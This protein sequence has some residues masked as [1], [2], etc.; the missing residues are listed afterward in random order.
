MRSGAGVLPFAD[1]CTHVSNAR[2]VRTAAAVVDTEQ[3]P[4]AGRSALAD[5]VRVLQAVRGG[6]VGAE[7]HRQALAGV[8]RGVRGGEFGK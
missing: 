2:V 5:E 3:A 1:G 8:V 7:E 6:D 4:V